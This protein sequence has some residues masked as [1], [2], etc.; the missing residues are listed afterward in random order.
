MCNCRVV[1]PGFVRTKMTAG[2]RPAPFAVDPETVAAAV[3]RGIERNQPVIWVPSALRWVFLALRA[4]APAALATAAGVTGRGARRPDHRR[5]ARSL[6]AGR[7][8]GGQTTNG[9]DRSRPAGRPVTTVPTTT[10]TTVPVEPGWTPI[11]IGPN[12]V[13]V[14]SGT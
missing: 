14:D 2:L 3:M 13:I 8:L 12:G 9:R 6:D 11:S 10:T 5:P 1:R 4:S 7:L